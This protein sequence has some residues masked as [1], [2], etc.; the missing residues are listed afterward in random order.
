MDTTLSDVTASGDV[1]LEFSVD[2]DGAPTDFSVIKSLDPLYDNKAIDIV[3]K[4]PKW[5]AGKKQK[6]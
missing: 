5:V 3:K 6:G 4:G 1:Q 2:E